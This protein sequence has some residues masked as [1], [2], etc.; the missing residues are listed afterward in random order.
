MKENFGQ[1]VRRKRNELGL[2]QTQLAVQIDMDAAKLSKIEN[3][4]FTINEE[5][6]V[7]L[8]QIFDVPEV[9]LKDFYYA[10]EIAKRIYKSGCS[11][12]VLTL[13]EDILVVYKSKDLKQ[14]E[15]K[16]DK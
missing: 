10:D 4:I 15:L 11:S 14:G 2:T 16:F 13:A 1:F 12:D 5:R 8:A 3:G 7:Q 9:E 6:L